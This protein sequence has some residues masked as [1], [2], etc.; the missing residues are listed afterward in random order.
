VTK[1]IEGVPESLTREQYVGLIES[2]GVDPDTLIEMNFKPDGIYATVAAEDGA[3]YA[4]PDDS[5]DEFSI[6]THKVYVPVTDGEVSS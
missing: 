4:V 5:A 2:V 3:G 6:M 1:I